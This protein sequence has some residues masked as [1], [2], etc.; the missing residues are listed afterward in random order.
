[1]NNGL[2]SIYFRLRKQIAKFIYILIQWASSHNS[3]QSSINVFW[4]HDLVIN[5]NFQ[6]QTEFFNLFSF[7]F[8]IIFLF[9]TIFNS[10]NF[11][12]CLRY[13]F[14]NPIFICLFWSNFRY[15]I[16]KL[17]FLLKAQILMTRLLAIN[18]FFLE[19]IK[20]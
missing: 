18:T 12:H 4:N 7:F 15:F 16:R 19:V 10:V 5:F 17:S 8:M 9:I 13:S 11:K 2:Y 6:N 3:K 14:I 1:M 20:K